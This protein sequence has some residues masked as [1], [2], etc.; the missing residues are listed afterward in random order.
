MTRLPGMIRVA[1]LA[2]G[3]VMGGV[4]PASA[5]QPLVGVKD[6]GSAPE[7]ERI[8]AAAR[9]IAENRRV[10]FV[11]G[12]F[13]GR[14][15]HPETK[16]RIKSQRGPAKPK[17]EADNREPKPVEILKTSFTFLDCMTY[18]EHV[19]ALA[20][21]DR[22]EY[23]EAFLPRLVDVMFDANG[24]PLMSHLRN[25]FTSHW[26]DVN[27]RKGYLTNIARG[28]PAAAKR[29]VMLN[30]VGNN[31]T[32]YVEDR[33]M[34][35]SSPQVV[36]YFPTKA[37]LERAAPLASGDILALVCDKEGLD[38]THMGFF[39]DQHGKRIFRHASMT[40]NRVVDQEFD[41]YM[42]EKKGLV[43]LMVFRPRLA[44]PLPPAYRFVKKQP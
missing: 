26:G 34:I 10:A 41:L 42:R 16:K 5:A 25:H 38:V 3:L 23:A 32:F 20:S 35:A 19:L 33:F 44:A 28:H 31:R 15:Y 8:I 6:F 22:P 2:L 1:V 24:A 13:L 17:R 7:A 37:V 39:I 29:E 43:G 27:E 14:K 11:S 40:L 4:S 21:A 9:G 36:W 18:V 12:Y 30:R